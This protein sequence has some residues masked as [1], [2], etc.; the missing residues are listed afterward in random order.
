MAAFCLLILVV[1][2][3]IG[4]LIFQMAVA[5]SFEIAS[6]YIAPDQAIPPLVWVP[7][8][9]AF[10]ALWYMLVGGPTIWLSL[11]FL[12]ALLGLASA[13]APPLARAPA[14]IRTATGMAR[15]ARWALGYNR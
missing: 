9:V 5:M 15:L 12:G 2:G 4:T 14:V 13:I 6:G 11:G 10:A 7:V 1:G 3:V 8:L